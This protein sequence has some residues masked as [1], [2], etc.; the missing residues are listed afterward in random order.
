MELTFEQIMAEL[1]WVLK[2]YEGRRTTAF[3]NQIDM[4]DDNISDV[5]LSAKQ[6]AHLQA[7]ADAFYKY[8]VDVAF[9]SIEEFYNNI[10]TKTN[11]EAT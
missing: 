2:F 3:W 10:W 6:P 5:D 7:F 9:L 4:N 11:S 1:V 8:T